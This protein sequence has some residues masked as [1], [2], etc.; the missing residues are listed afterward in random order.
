MVVCL[1]R[2][3][4][5]EQA[6]INLMKEMSGNT[7]VL[8]GLTDIETELQKGRPLEFISDM[9]YYNGYRFTSAHDFLVYVLGYKD[10]PEPNSNLATQIE[11]LTEIQGLL[12]EGNYLVTMSGSWA[13]IDGRRQNA[14]LYLNYMGV[15]DDEL[16][17]LYTSLRN[18]YMRPGTTVSDTMLQ[19]LRE[20]YG[21][22]LPSG[23]TKDELIEEVHRVLEPGIISSI[24][25][26]IEELNAGEMV[27]P[28]GPPADDVNLPSGDELITAIESKMDSLNSFSQ[29][30][31]IEL[32]SETNKRDQAYDMI[33]NI[34]KSLNT[35]QVGIVNNI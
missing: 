18:M 32:Q 2:A 35:V 10:L 3:A 25:A 9:Y 16:F 13:D 15:L 22:D 6:V 21:I 19:E 12:S 4:E 33:T 24:A 23:T 5:K 26:K 1:A 28:L 8:E 27:M 11:N 29:Q 20:N 14:I 34:L 30:K 31:M 7:T 17:E